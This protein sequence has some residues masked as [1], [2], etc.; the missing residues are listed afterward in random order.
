MAETG[1]QTNDALSDRE[2]GDVL[3]D[4]VC[5]FMAEDEE[6]RAGDPAERTRTERLAEAQLLLL[7][8]IYCE[9]RHGHDQTRQHAEELDSHTAAMS[10]LR[11]ALY[12]HGAAMG[13]MVGAMADHAHEMNPASTGAVASAS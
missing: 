6:E 1:E 12:D 8:A 5:Q 13:R 9:L 2:R 7:Q 11:G 3:Y 10:R 4:L